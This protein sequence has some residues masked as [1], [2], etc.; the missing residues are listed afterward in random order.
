LQNRT[1]VCIIEAEVSDLENLKYPLHGAAAR[2]ALKNALL[3]KFKMEVDVVV[4]DLA[5]FKIAT[6][7]DLQQMVNVYK[8]R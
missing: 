4:V 2:D 3:A 6:P 1:H 8:K 7:K 5:A